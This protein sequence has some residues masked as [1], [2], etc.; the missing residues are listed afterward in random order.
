[1]DKQKNTEELFM[2]KLISVLAIIAVIMMV[3][4]CGGGSTKTKKVDDFK[5]GF[6]LD[7]DNILFTYQETD[8]ANFDPV[9][10]ITVAG[11]FNGW[12]PAAPDW[13]ATDDDGDGVW[14]FESTLEEVPCGTQFKFVA[15]TVDWQQPPADA[16]NASGR[17]S[18]LTDDGF[19]GFNLVLVCD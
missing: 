16:L 8:Y 6:Q 2:K 10:A 12:D 18:S 1:L 9:E 14:T 19:G 3:F 17:G 7:G 4:A 13:Q 11:E 5:T 15:N